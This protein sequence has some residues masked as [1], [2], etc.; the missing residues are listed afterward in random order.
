QPAAEWPMSDAGRSARAA[1]IL[2]PPDTNKARPTRTRNNKNQGLADG[3]GATDQRPRRGSRGGARG[4]GALG[5][6]ARA[7][8]HRGGRRRA[9]GAR[10]ARRSF[11]LGV[12]SAE[13]VL[14]Y[15]RD[16]W[17]ATG[18]GLDVAHAELR[19]LEWLLTTLLAERGAPPR[20][21]LRFDTG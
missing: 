18:L 16:R 12:S 6:G 17:R 3:A 10:L 2:R 21:H 8:D 11:H 15:E 13:L 14:T 20:V 9:R 1:A 7:L 5:N 19:G 4:L